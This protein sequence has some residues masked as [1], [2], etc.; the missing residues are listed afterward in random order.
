M[1]RSASIVYIKSGQ[2]IFL[3][4]KAPWGE[5]GGEIIFAGSANDEG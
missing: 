1:G 5:S 4:F 2:R 3:W